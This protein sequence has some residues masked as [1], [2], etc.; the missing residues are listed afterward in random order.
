MRV[1]A[2]VA[3]MVVATACG[4]DRKLARKLETSASWIAAIDMAG[5][6][7]TNNRVPVRFA[8][9]L[10][11]EGRSQLNTASRQVRHLRSDNPDQAAAGDALEDAAHAAD[12]VLAALEQRDAQAVGDALSSLGAYRVIMD[13]LATRAKLQ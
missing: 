9:Q 10:M 1:V 8:R 4:D 12:V 3:A 13:S 6:S 11:E 5:R 2:L 7:W